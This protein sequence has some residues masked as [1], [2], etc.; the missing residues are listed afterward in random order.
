MHIIESGH[1]YEMKNLDPNPGYSYSYLTFVKRVGPQYPGNIG[2]HGG[3]TS[4]EVIRCL[5]DRAQYVN[6]QIPCWQTKLSIYLYGLIIWLYEHRAA[7][8]HR[9]KAPSFHDA[10]FG[11]TCDK[12][13]HVGCEQ[14]KGGTAT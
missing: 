8:R 13:G 10:T 12:C 4:Q 5:I 6:R 3:T 9:R 14:D 2:A 11:E 1:G 7:K